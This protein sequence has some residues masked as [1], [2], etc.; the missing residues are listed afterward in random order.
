MRP[1]R[2]TDTSARNQ[3]IID[4]Y[5]TGTVTQE[6]IGQRFGLTTMSV[7]KILKSQMGDADNGE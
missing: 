1:D 3:K 4:L 6:A 5:A 2:V 7:R